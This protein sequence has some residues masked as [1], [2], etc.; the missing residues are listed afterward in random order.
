MTLIKNAAILK[1]YGFSVTSF[2]DLGML[3]AGT[4]TLTLAT[5][6]PSVT[7]FSCRNSEGLPWQLL[8]V[9]FC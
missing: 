1:D 7:S 8:Q 6:S 2:I 3:P 4:T 9:L 5:F